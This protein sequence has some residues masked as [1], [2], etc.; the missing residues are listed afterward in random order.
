MFPRLK[1]PPWSK[2]GFPRLGVREMS[3]AEAEQV[4]EQSDHHGSH[5]HGHDPHLAHH[6]ETM[7][8]Q[9]DAGK[10]GIWLFLVT[11]VLFFSG[12]FV[13]YAVYRV[14][15]PEV[16]VEAHHYLNTT[17]GAFNTVVLLVSSLTM[18]WAVRAAQLNQQQLLIRLLAITLG[19]ASLFL[20][21]KAVEYSHK[22]GL[23][24]LW[25]GA[26]SAG[27]VE[28][29]VAAE[30]AHE[31]GSDDVSDGHSD[32]LHVDSAGEHEDGGHGAAG[33]ADDKAHHDTLIALLVLC[34]PACLG[35]AICAGG[36]N[37][38]K[39]RSLP[40]A[41][42][43][44]TLLVGV[45]L[46]F[47]AGVALGQIVEGFS[48]HGGDSTSHHAETEKVKTAEEV[49]VARRYT[50]VFFSIYYCMTG[51]HAIH[52]LGGMGVIGW[53]LWRSIRGDFGSSYFG[54]VDYVGLYWHL[55]D[56]VWIYLFPLLYLIR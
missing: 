48:G 11:E 32:V 15:H 3:T 26:Y 41:K 34:L 45:G 21:V 23:G 6:F 31:S 27:D 39:K 20:G 52:I 50:G 1:N 7:E 14:L 9:F 24:L 2:Q 13:A 37:F 53:L 25:A 33:H 46:A 16:F 47:F 42:T 51:V 12:L 30:A 35:V 8:Q 19:C 40:A 10:L 43:F 18:A 22:W 38:A 17:L 4:E 56:L 54:P 44:W 36:V 49:E 55:V 5:D 28:T 29:E